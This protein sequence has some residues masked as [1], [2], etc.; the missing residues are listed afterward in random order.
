MRNFLPYILLYIILSSLTTQASIIENVIDN[1]GN[2]RKEIIDLLVYTNPDVKLPDS[3]LKNIIAPTQKYWLRQGA[4]RWDEKDL[5]GAQNELDQKIDD[6]LNKLGLKEPLTPQMKGHKFVAAFGGTTDAMTLRVAYIRDM[7]ERGDF[8]GKVLLFG[9]TSDCSPY[10]EGIKALIKAQPDWFTTNKN[11]PECL[12]ETGVLN[13]LAENFIQPTNVEY[14]VIEMP[15]VSLP[16]QTSRKANTED[17]AKKLKKITNGEGPILFVSNS[18]LG[19]RQAVVLETIIPKDA[20]DLAVFQNEFE[21][22]IRKVFQLAGNVEISPALKLDN[23]ARL[24]YQINSS[25]K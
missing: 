3:K 18:D 16:N 15:N 24:L 20:L 4:V 14:E 21:P 22:K 19:I 6:V 17:Q 9:S 7:I 11:L 1:D 10:L 2:V 23:L 13:F 12:T 5:G 8:S 25:M